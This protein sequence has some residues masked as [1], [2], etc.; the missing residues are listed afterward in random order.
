MHELNNTSV[1]PLVQ[2]PYSQLTPGA[3]ELARMQDSFR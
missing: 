1:T 2:L 3:A